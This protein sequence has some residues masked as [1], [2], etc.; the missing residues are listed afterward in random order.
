MSK[1]LMCVDVRGNRKQWGFMFY[2]DPK[3]LADWR[4]DG[5]VVDEVENIIPEW[6]VDLGLV[7]PWCFL[8]DLL[9]FKNPLGR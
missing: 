7:R 8:Q 6:V 5:L 1:K 9:N 2:G 3:H 4:A